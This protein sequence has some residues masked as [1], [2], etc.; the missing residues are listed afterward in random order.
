M[1]SNQLIQSV[2]A[3]S[4]VAVILFLIVVDPFGEASG[5][6]ALVGWVLGFSAWSLLRHWRIADEVQLA[7]TKFSFVTGACGGLAIAFAFVVLMRVAPPVADFVANIAAF[8]NNGLPLA[9]VGF[10]LGSLATILIVMIST[11]VGY[12]FWWSAR[13]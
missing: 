7:A 5:K 10:A 13:S 2:A 6:I 1:R 9:A 11:I 12:V 4:A 8:S 3:I